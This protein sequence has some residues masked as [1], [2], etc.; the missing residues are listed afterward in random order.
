MAH[1]QRRHPAR[2]GPLPETPQRAAVVDL[3]DLG[4]QVGEAT[5]DRVEVG[6]QPVARRGHRGGAQDHLRP[7]RHA[8]YPRAL[9]GQDLDDLVA[10]G[11]VPDAS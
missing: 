7:R 2:P 4:A 1:R 3:Q 9:A 8:A 5:T 11:G 10:A 6:Q